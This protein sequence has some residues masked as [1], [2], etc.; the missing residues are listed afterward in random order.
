MS[1]Y[2]APQQS[3]APNFRPTYSTTLAFAFLLSVVLFCF[4]AAA[5]RAQTG[6]P[7]DDVVRIRTDLVAVPAIVIDAKGRRVAGITQSEFKVRDNGQEV[8][9]SYFATGSERVALAFALDA[10]G[11]IR[12]VIAQ[13][14]DAALKLFSR[15]GRGSRVAVVHFGERATLTTPFTTEA[16]QSNV[17]FRAQRPLD[18][19]TAIFD[20]VATT[21]AAFRNQGA[22]PT[23]RRILI[24]ISDGLDTASTNSASSVIE[25]ARRLGVSIYV[26]HLPLYTPRD[27]NLVARPATKGFRDLA[28]KT[29]GRYFVV[30]DAKSAL[31]PSAV[32]DLEPVFH[33]IDEDLRGQYVLGYYPDDSARLTALHHIDVSLRTRRSGKLRVMSLRDQISLRQ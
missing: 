30:G 7:P 25:A 32:S 10:S 21:L 24:L 33:A 9:L 18:R 3:K 19:H 31:N 20:A 16:D 22:D 6:E 13:Q 15:F 12:E 17:Q 1:S 27:G 8:T 14:R 4:S 5:V 23:E 2:L 11:S 29:G 28:E 26:I